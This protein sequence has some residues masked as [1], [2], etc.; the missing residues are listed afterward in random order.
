MD[1]H[2][3]LSPELDIHPTDFVKAWNDDTEAH[4]EASASFAPSAGTQYDP[5]LIADVLLGVTTGI[6]S[7]ALYELIKKVLVKQGV[8]KHTHIEEMKKSDGSRL[9]VIDIKE[10]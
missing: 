1:Y 6:A 2:I 8:R 3:A 9:L 7:N 10:K 5:T 4:N